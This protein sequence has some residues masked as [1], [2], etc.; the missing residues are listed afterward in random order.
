MLK[1]LGLSFV[2]PAEG[3]Q[4]LLHT[5]ASLKPVLRMESNKL[6]LLDYNTQDDL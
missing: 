2:S 3:A 5:E 1:R 6:S 4:V